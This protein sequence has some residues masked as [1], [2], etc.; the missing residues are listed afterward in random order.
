MLDKG[1]FIFQGNFLKIFRR[2]NIFFYNLAIK[3]YKAEDQ[4]TPL[5]VAFGSI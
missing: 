2:L 5:S 4:E 3:K 1:L